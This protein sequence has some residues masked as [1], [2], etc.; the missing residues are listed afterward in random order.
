MRRLR[1]EGES[2][3][4]M[5]VPKPECNHPICLLA[6]DLVNKLSTIIGR[7]DLLLERGRLQGED[8]RDLTQIHD[9]AKSICARFQQPECPPITGTRIFRD[10]TEFAEV[11]QRAPAIKPRVIERDA[12]PPAAHVRKNME[13]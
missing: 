12:P 13:I 6:H 1:G 7:C 2:S 9:T 11:A 3:A 8:A 10:S 5:Q 4:K